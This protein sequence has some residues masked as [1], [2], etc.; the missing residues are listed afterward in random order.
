MLGQPGAIGTSASFLHT[1]L[2]MRNRSR[3]ILEHLLEAEALECLETLIE[4]WVKAV[5]SG[6]ESD[7]ASILNLLQTLDAARPRSAMPAIFNAIYSRTNP[8][9]LDSRQKSSLS[10]NL[11]ESEIVA[12]LVE[13]SSSLEDDVLD[14]IWIDCTT[15]LRDIL[16]NPMP[17]RQILCR[18]L[19]FITVLGGKMENTNFG[20]EWKMR[21]ELG[22]RLYVPELDSLG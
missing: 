1:S 20:E 14:E 16:A 17:H 6:S 11:S 18:L 9:A 8:T 22:V 13:Y 15:F 7:S 5:K 19:I 10:S 12:F 3:R 21:R 4:L 2:K